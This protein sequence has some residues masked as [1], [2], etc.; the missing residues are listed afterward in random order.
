MTYVSGFVLAA[1]VEAGSRSDLVRLRPRPQQPV[2]SDRLG[3]G[4]C[5]N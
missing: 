3:R 4:S 1:L 5:R 2:E